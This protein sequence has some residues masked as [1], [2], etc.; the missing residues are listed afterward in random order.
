MKKEIL[1]VETREALDKFDD[2]FL[3]YFLSCDSYEKSL[4]CYAIIQDKRT[5]KEILERVLIPNFKDDG[6]DFQKLTLRGEWYEYQEDL[7]YKLDYCYDENVDF[8]M[9]ENGNQKTYR[10]DPKKM[11]TEAIE[12]L[13]STFIECVFASRVSSVNRIIRY[14][15]V[16]KI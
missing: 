11:T 2:I 5:T 12:D 3:E 4:L 9:D 10:P 1:D 8:I 14:N 6:R 15:S 7:R 13:K 16:Y